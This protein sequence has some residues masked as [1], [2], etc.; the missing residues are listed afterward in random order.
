LLLILLHM[1]LNWFILTPKGPLVPTGD[2]PV[3]GCVVWSHTIFRFFET[4]CEDA[5][6]NKL[7]VSANFMIL[8]ATVQ[9]LWVFEIFR[10]TLGRAGMC[11][12]Q[13]GG[14]DQSAQKWGKKEEKKGRQEEKWEGKKKKMGPARGR[15]AT[16]GCRPAPTVWP[17]VGSW[18]AAVDQSPTAGGRPA[19]VDQRSGGWG[20][21]ATS[22]RPSAAGLSHCRLWGLKFLIF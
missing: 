15:W 13:W 7:R 18:S 1:F 12:S 3:L 19:V 16:A 8:G 11:C 2:K 10:W 5:S 14:V 21:A 6:R 20:K 4:F 9:K 17:L 22:S